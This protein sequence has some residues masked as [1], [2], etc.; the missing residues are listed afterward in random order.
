MAEETAQQSTT[1]SQPAAQPKRV[2]TPAPSAPSAP[3]SPT[4]GCDIGKNCDR[5][6]QFIATSNGVTIRICE[7]HRPELESM[8]PDVTFDV[9]DA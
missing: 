8:Y 9:K 4:S 6:V 7:V 1:S 3:H 5:T 2:A